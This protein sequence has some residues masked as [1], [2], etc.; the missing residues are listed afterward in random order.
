MTVKQIHEADDLNQ[1]KQLAVD[2]LE[3]NQKLEGHNAWLNRQLFG[4]K[5]ERFE[6]PNQQTLGFTTDGADEAAAQ[7]PVT[8]NLAYTRKKPAGRGK[9]QPIPAD[10]PRIER[11]YDLPDDQ[12]T[13]PAT[14]QPLKKIGEEVTEQLSWLPGSIRVIRH[15]RIKYARPGENLDGQSPEVVT[16]QRPK[17]GL[18]K[19]LAAPDLLAQIIVSKYGD[20]LPLDRLVKIFKR[21]GFELSKASMCRWVQGVGELVQPLVDLMKR[22]MIDNCRVIQTDETPVRQQDPG[23]GSTKEC[24]FWPYLG[25]PGTDGHYVVFDYTQSRSGEHPRRW[26]R[27]KEDEPLFVGGLLQGDGY[28]GVNQL[29][30]PEKPWK[31]INV[32]CW[33][34]ARRKFYDARQNSPGLSHY[35]LGIIQRMYQVEADAKNATASERK[36]MRDATSL[37]LVAEFFDWCREQQIKALPKSKFGVALTYALNQEGSLRRY[38]DEGDLQIDNNACE[39]TLRGIAIGR[40]NWLFIGSPAG[41]KAAAQVFSVLGS[42]QLHGVEPLSYLTDVITRLPSTS[43]DRIEQFLPDV[44]AKERA[45]AAET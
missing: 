6:D 26:F 5:A 45:D 31:M 38:L 23:R 1:L 3:H 29:F 13:D 9:R 34:H 40:K 22:R 32:G 27:G 14:G 21:S 30:D 25:Q 43:V 11:R 18:P 4:K 24:R 19:C 8:E 7:P 41:G 42:A 36:A 44:W 15:V 2:L 35:A 16:A 12:K 37:P 10:L 33:A 17:E 39:R 20:H 28:A